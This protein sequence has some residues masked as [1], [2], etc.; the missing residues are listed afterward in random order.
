MVIS[1]I[2]I[3]TCGHSIWKYAKL[4]KIIKNYVFHKIF[5]RVTVQYEIIKVLSWH[6]NEQF[7]VAELFE[8]LGSTPLEF[9]LLF[10]ISFYFFLI[11]NSFSP[12]LHSRSTLFTQLF[13]GQSHEVFFKL[14]FNTA[15]TIIILS[16]HA[17]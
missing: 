6:I 8:R 4:S 16:H 13:L 5:D 17:E 7:F 1:Q 12:F 10:I 9:L 14:F 2:K 3:I 11:L 15:Y